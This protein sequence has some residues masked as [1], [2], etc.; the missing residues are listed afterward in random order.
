MSKVSLHFEDDSTGLTAF[1]ADW[2]GGYDINS[3]A[4]RLACTVIKFLDDQAVKK[5][6]VP[7]S[8]EETD[9]IQN[10]AGVPHNAA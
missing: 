2:K 10:G 1:R 6:L 8:T 3:P 9:T 5:Q 7:P 4:H